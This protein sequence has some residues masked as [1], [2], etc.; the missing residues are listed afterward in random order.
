MTSHKLA[1]AAARKELQI[2]TCCF[3]LCRRSTSAIKDREQIRLL[4]WQGKRWRCTMGDVIIHDTHEMGSMIERKKEKTKKL[5]YETCCN[6]IMDR[7][8]KLTA[9]K[10]NQNRKNLTATRPNRTHLQQNIDW[11]ISFTCVHTR[12]SCSCSAENSSTSSSCSYY[13]LL[14]RNYIKLLHVKTSSSSFHS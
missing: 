2:I 1:A 4:L 13:F 6:M 3:S 14:S 5:M 12:S 9:A 10:Q 7:S 8:L 11:T